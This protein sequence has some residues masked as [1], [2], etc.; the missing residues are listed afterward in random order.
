MSKKRFSIST[1]VN[2]ALTQTIQMAEAENSIFRNTEI[3]VDRI[4]VDPNNPRNHH[5]TLRDIQSG[6]SSAD[7][8][9]AIKQNE[10]D[11]LCELA[12]SIK[13]DG[14]LNP[15]TVI[16][17]G[18]DFKLVAGERRF[19]ATMIAKKNIIEARVFKKKPKSLD[20]KIVQWS[21]NQSRQD[22]SLYEKLMNVS[23]ICEAYQAEKQETLT[24]IKLSEIIHVSRQQAQFY[25][26][27]LS[28]TDLMQL[29]QNGEVST[30]DM[31]RKLASLTLEQIQRKLNQLDDV[32]NVK[33]VAPVIEQDKSKN[34]G[35]KR[36]SV[37]LG[38]TK[39]PFVAQTLAEAILSTNRFGKYAPGFQ[40]VDWTC[41]DQSTKAFQKLI[42]IMEKE[43]GVPA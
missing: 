18:G 2:T 32:T 1:A 8:D 5:I 11:S 15:I 36:A 12:D 6:L 42:E 25:V 33:K 35:R 31:A 14:L 26:A 20:L 23:A 13:K 28:N 16:E 9:Y 39:K 43:L 37:N 29:I 41:L 24:A 19:L 21:E 3:L 40:P 7:P 30:L 22:L 27:I 4:R 38:S 34:P 10:Y 17:E